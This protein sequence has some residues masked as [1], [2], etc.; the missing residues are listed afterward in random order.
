MVDL[1]IAREGRWL[2]AYVN[3]ENVRTI[4]IE[5]WTG[6]VIVGFAGTSQAA[7]HM[8]VTS[9]HHAEVAYVPPRPT[10]LLVH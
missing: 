10:T 5:D 2:R 8:A 7:E 3:G 6:P 9:F 1:E 4:N